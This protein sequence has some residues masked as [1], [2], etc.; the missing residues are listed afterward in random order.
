MG[1]SERALPSNQEAR[2]YYDHFRISNQALAEWA[3]PSG[4][5]LFDDDFDEYGTQPGDR[6]DE[7]SANAVM[8]TLLQAMDAVVS[9]TEGQLV[10]RLRDSA[11]AIGPEAPDVAV[12]LLRMALEL[13]PDG[14]LIQRK[15]RE[16]EKL[17]Q[18]RLTDESSG[19]SSSPN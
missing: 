5:M 4:E 13:R 16:F 2:D 14:Q 3:L 8:V 9:R 6:W 10:G 19:S 7:D 18:N 1:D 11:L 12:A 15:L 17:A